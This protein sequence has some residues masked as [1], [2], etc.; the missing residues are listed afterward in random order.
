MKN[1]KTVICTLPLRES[2]SMFPPIGSLSTITALKNAGY[3]DTSLYNLDLHRPTLHEIE[4]YFVEHKPDIIGLSAVTSTTYSHIKTISSMLKEILPYS[5]IIMGGNLAAS[6][7]IVLKKTKVDII[8]TGEGEIDLLN[9]CNSINNFGLLHNKHIYTIDGICYLDENNNLIVNK[10]SDVLPND[11]IYDI[12]WS[13][14]EKD[15]MKCYLEP[16]KNVSWLLKDERINEPHRKGKYK[17]VIV[18]S[19]GC[20]AKCTFCHRFTPGMRY[21]PIQ[22]VMN[23]ID[24]FIENYNVGTIDFGDENFGLNPKW[25]KEFC[26]EIKKRDILWRC[27]ARV[28]F[29]P[30]SEKIKMLK[31]SGC[32][33]INYGIE[34]GSDKML[35]V[36]EK[37]STAKK[38]IRALNNTIDGGLDTTIQIIIGMPGENS[39]TIHETSEFIKT[40]VQNSSKY[41]PNQLSLNFAQAL[42]GTP[43]YEYGRKNGIIGTS[44]D[45]EEA[46]LLNI[47]G[48]DA[49]DGET[50]KNFTSYPKLM[51]EYWLYFLH[52]QARFDYIEA[53][54]LDSYFNLVN[55]AGADIGKHL[56]D[57][58]SISIED[59]KKLNSDDEPQIAR[60][61]SGYFASPARLI[62]SNY[63][64]NN[65]GLIQLIKKKEFGMIFI[66]YP[67]QSYYIFKYFGIPLIVAKTI[68][69][70]G[71]SKAIKDLREYL[72]SKYIKIR[73]NKNVINFDYQSLRE[74]NYNNPINENCNVDDGMHKL[75]LGR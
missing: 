14:L 54:G 10:D 57:V 67:K 65:L 36:M 50:T 19:K 72:V 40:I 33:C 3:K 4:K 46:Y 15:E 16:M 21:I 37:R 53:W 30:T 68:K 75:R 9:I 45:D 43:L 66:L 24:Y 28:D 73:Q 8:C 32:V 64:A 48:K 55:E 71:L 69:S 42:P 1:I 6:A 39:K 2:P 11:R 31:D 56:V 18:A 61:D 70:Y 49:R 13:I 47:S 60:K 38:N 63:N 59:V 62:E 34:S 17:A 44:V 74:Y 7:E 20:V 35:K 41:D 25:I 12:D 26:K 58:D 52:I 23:R 29:T 51:L 27:E 5:L 22:I